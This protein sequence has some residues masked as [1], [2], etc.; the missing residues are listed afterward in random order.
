VSG[1]I[2]ANLRNFGEK[3]NKSGSLAKLEKKSRVERVK[4]FKPSHILFTFKD[5]IEFKT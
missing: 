3:I 1:D 5:L 2:I 4:G